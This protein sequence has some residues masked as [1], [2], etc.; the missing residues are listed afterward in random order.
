MR[1]GIHILLLGLSMAACSVPPDDAAKPSTGGDA[2]PMG[3]DTAAPNDTGSPPD[4]AVDADGDGYDSDVDC[5]DNEARVNPA[6]SERCDG[7]DNNCDGLIDEGLLRMFYPDLDIDGYGDDAAAVEACERPD[8]WI[9]RG[10]DCDDADAAVNPDASEYCDEVDNDCD[11]TVDGPEPLDPS[12]FFADDDG[13]GFGTEASTI[14]A[15]SP[16]E[17]F[18]PDASDCDDS[19]PF[20]SPFG[21]EVCDGVD[22]D[23]DGSVDED[24]D[25]DGSVWYRDSD[26]DGF[27]DI[28]VTHVSCAAPSGYVGNSDDCDDTMSVVFPDAEEY[29]NDIDDDCDGAVDEGFELSTY[30]ADADGDGHGSGVDPIISCMSLTGYAAVGDDCDDD[31]YWAHPGLAELCDGIDND[32]D[33]IVDEEIVFTDFVPDDDG[34]GYGDASG[35]VTSACSPPPGMVVDTTDCDDSNP[36]VYP[37]VTE[38]CNGLDDNCDGTID[39]FMPS[40]T[41]YEDADGDGYGVPDSSTTACT[42]P[43][44]YSSLDSDCDDGDEGIHPGAYEFC[45]GED[46]DCDGVIDDDCGFSRNFVLFVTDTFIGS[47]ES[48]WL[49]DREAADAKCTDYAASSGIAGSDFRIVYSTPDEDARDYL[50]YEPGLDQ[51]YDRYGTSISDEDMYDG[52]SPVLPD[53]KSWTIQGSGSDGRFSECSGS[54]PSGSWP[55][56]QYCSEKFTCG[57]SSDAMFA[58]SAC[59]WTGNRAVIC[60]GQTD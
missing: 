34:D 11:G 58:V 22:N 56:C 10:G 3:S 28:D 4:E 42:L 57:S 16:P 38:L 53:M 45:D 29:C 60:M 47:A 51:L 19:D 13:D 44:G 52:S 48:S 46:D 49:T 18:T 54:Y 32:C 31:E 9:G 26:G 24:S 15:C 5:D 23:C 39:E 30:Y 55:I 33:G 37:G 12:V 36:E 6:A 27:G 8:G 7:I 20:I 35:P 21:F 14:D 50:D 41:Y 2:P 1:A 25:F 17:G 40:Y 59:C 43:P